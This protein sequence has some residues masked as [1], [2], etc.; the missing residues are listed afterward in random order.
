M[1]KKIN[2]RKPYSG[3]IFFFAANAFNEGRFKDYSHSGL[4]INTMAQLSVGEVIAIAI[5]FLKNKE[6]K[7]KG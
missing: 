3:H 1:N 6:V 5:P 7:C 4:V 2:K